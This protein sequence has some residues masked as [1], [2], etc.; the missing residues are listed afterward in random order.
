MSHASAIFFSPS[1]VAGLY[2]SMSDRTVR[3]ENT[4]MPAFQKN[5]PLSKYACALG[6]GGF[7]TNRCTRNAS[8]PSA[9]PGS[10]SAC[11][12]SMYP[13]PVAG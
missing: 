1:A 3:A 9:D 10:V 11:P 6:S 13:N 2:F 12:C 8:P 5:C 7:S 4:N